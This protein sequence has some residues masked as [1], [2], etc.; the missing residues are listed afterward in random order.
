MGAKGKRYVQA[1]IKRGL[2]FGMGVNFVM[3][4]WSIIEKG[5]TPQVCVEAIRQAVSERDLS[6]VPWI[7]KALQDHRGYFENQFYSFVECA[8]TV[9]ETA[10]FA[11]GEMAVRDAIPAIEKMMADRDLD[12]EVRSTC[13]WVLVKLDAIPFESI[14]PKMTASDEEIVEFL[15]FINLRSG[16]EIDRMLLSLANDSTKS[17]RVRETA[18]SSLR[19]SK[20]NVV[21]RRRWWE[22]RVE[23]KDMDRA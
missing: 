15:G 22:W 3:R 12:V 10:L 19:Q 6:A 1:I 11:L 13:K 8:T 7:M 14:V 18:E 16:V 9:R 21:R 5:A 4:D 17:Q 2:G 23:I 20:K